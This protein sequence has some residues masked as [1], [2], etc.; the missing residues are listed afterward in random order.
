[1]EA[2]LR[3]TL[4][5]VLATLYQYAEKVAVLEY[6]R[7]MARRSIDLA[8][9]L[10]DRKRLLVKVALDTS[11]VTRGEVLDLVNLSSVL[12]VAPLIVA[13]TH[14]GQE[15]IEG[16]AYDRLGVKSVSPET[17][18]ATL[19]GK[20]EVYVYE[21]RDS[22]RVRINPEALRRKRQELGLSLGDLAA[23]LGTSRKAVYDYERG[24]V[25]PTL[26]RAEVLIRILGEDVLEP[27]DIFEPPR[28]VR[29]SSGSTQT[30]LEEIVSRLLE[31][32]GYSVAHARRTVAD[33]G[34]SSQEKRFLFVLD[35]E[36]PRRRASEEK[37]AYFQELARVVGVDEH[38][39]ITEN[40]V[41]AKRLDREG[42]R[43]YTPEEIGEMVAG[44]GARLLPH[45]KPRSREEHYSGEDS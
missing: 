42:V 37:I 5:R 21:S 19:S 11:Q 45:R 22:F 15:M 3:E 13:R 7:R 35:E 26:E 29:A 36:H 28:E 17:L 30:R 40:S 25:D 9:S 1:M 10:P 2:G 8:V 18:E 41:R 23:R 24:R 12:G 38:A 31:E 4:Y 6:P 43:V 39:V 14:H 32:A 34:C 44:H 33:L 27:V 20:G 16:V